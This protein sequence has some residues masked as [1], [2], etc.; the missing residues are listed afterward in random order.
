MIGNQGNR[1]CDPETQ[2]DDMLFDGVC[3]YIR[4]IM[5]SSLD[6]T[7]SCDCVKQRK[8]ISYQIVIRLIN[9]SGKLVFAIQ[10]CIKLT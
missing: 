9:E 1:K 2:A 6:A 3:H 8:I 5:L 7:V 10:G 4:P